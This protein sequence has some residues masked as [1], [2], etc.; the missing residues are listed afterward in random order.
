MNFHLPQI[1]LSGIILIGMGINLAR[2]GQPKKDTVDTV[3]CLVAPAI[4][5]GLLWWGG[6]YG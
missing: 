1:I 2:Y 3:D 6:F 4:V 5:L